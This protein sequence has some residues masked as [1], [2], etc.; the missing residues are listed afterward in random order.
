[1]KK[2]IS[3]IICFSMLVMS[4]SGMVFTAYAEELGTEETPYII[5]T[6]DQFIEKVKGDQTGV[7]YEIQADI[8]LSD[9]Y[10]PTTFVGNLR[11]AQK[12]DGTKYKITVDI[13]S[14]NAG[15]IGLFAGFSGTVQNLEI[16]GNITSTA[17]SGTIRLGGLA[18][19]ID[20]ASEISNC[21]S[22]VNITAGAAYTGGLI[23]LINTSGAAVN[24]TDCSFS[25][26]ISS[27][28]LYTAGIVGGVLS[29]SA[30]I[31]DC[32]NY[33]KVYY[34]PET[35]STAITYIGGIIGYQR[36]ANVSGCVNETTAEVK[37][38]LSGETGTIYIG[39]ISGYIYTGYTVSDCVN[40][41]T[42]S[43]LSD[44]NSNA[45]IGGIAGWSHGTITKSSNMSDN[46]S[47]RQIGGIVGRNS[48]NSTVNYC[49][50]TGNLPN[51]AGYKGGLAARNDNIITNCF[52]LGNATAQHSGGIAGTN[53]GKVTN[54]YTVVSTASVNPVAY[55]SSGT[56]TN[57]YYVI[58][59]DGSVTDAT[60]GTKT[61]FND[62][63]NNTTVF[64]STNGWQILAESDTNKYLLPQLIDNPYY[65]SFSF[66]QENTTDYAGGMGT[67]E[68]PFKISNATHFAN[69]SKN[70]NAWYILTGNITVDTPVASF[71]GVFDGDGKTITLEID[72]TSTQDTDTGL[73]AS[74]TASA[75]V[76]NLVLTG[77]V[78]GVKNVGA[79]A[80]TSATGSKV[81]NIIINK[82]TSIEG[83]IAGGI[84]GNNYSAITKCAN[85]GYILSSGAAGGIAGYSYSPITYS[86]NTGKVKSTFAGSTPA[87][88][89]GHLRSVAAYIANCYNLGTIEGEN[90][91]GLAGSFTH[92]NSIIKISDSFN[93]GAVIRADETEPVIQRNNTSADD[94][95]LP[96]LT[97]VYYLTATAYDDGYENSTNI[98]TLEALQSLEINGFTTGGTYPVIT[99]NPQ[100]NLI[101][102]IKLSASLSENGNVTLNS[103]GTMKDRFIKA[104]ETVSVNVT[105]NTGY[106][107]TIT[108][109]GTAVKYDIITSDT[110]T[111]E[112]LTADTIIAVTFAE[113]PVTDEDE[114]IVTA[115]IDVKNETATSTYNIT[116]QNGAD[117]YTIKEGETYVV[118]FGT[119]ED[120]YGWEIADFGVEIDGKKWASKTG[121]SE[122]NSFGIL[123]EKFTGSANAK[124][125]VEYKLADGTSKTV[126]GTE[127]LITVE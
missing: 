38:T 92:S 31:I 2:F 18:G 62:I 4:I 6:P 95:N 78:K 24:V 16:T 14:S 79:V 118:V 22:S 108:C 113:R 48:S 65:G 105:P 86:Y 8:D 45:Y 107:G 60:I 106:M 39:G 57:V 36:F 76:K 69:I 123:F 81:E 85:N 116:D 61:S 71:G 5:T 68:S 66:P 9:G 70:S 10:T 17:T 84:I 19:L 11:G 37:D 125:Y 51:T 103:V 64:N 58:N 96:Q 98:T 40:K 121:L 44:N 41:G 29:N 73:F 93:A 55:A 32:T 49:Y 119:L 87:G 15:N 20:G 75:E 124:I 80:G 104:G 97:N 52:N 102:I 46:L 30:N 120:F 13:T 82:S 67:E 115:P 117:G 7:W 27:K 114:L 89:A 1:M 50:N 23:G 101:R 90:A 111:T 77:T 25:G 74:L 88:I 42:V 59:T 109:N 26:T 33:G 54:A 53:L 110:Y 21:I 122:S 3:V 127:S 28:G 94:S 72:T 126:Y 100:S 99:D 63:L 12:P 83:N 43:M 34:E 47:G 56:L 91:V 35:N 112:T